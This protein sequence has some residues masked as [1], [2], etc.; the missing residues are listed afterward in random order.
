MLIGKIYEFAQHVLD[1]VLAK[2]LCIVVRN[3]LL[4][5]LMLLITAATDA[6]ATPKQNL[7]P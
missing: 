6:W 2:H 5:L 4:T 3:R 7:S 1:F